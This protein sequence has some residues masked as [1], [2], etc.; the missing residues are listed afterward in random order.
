MNK[1]Y[2]LL[3]SVAAFALSVPALAADKETYESKTKIESDAKGNYDEKS[4]VEKTDSAGTETAVEKK[5]D[6]DVD[7]KGNVDKSVKTVETTDPKGLFNKTK[8]KT[9]DTK[10]TQ[11]DGSVKVT[12]K[13][14][15]NGDTVEKTS[16]T[17]NPAR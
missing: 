1:T 12:H 8:V 13:K 6:V 14:V 11:S 10:K 5:V 4:K 7:A 9:T 16:E 2:I 3:A 15:V 17:V